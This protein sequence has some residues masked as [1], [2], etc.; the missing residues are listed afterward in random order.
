MELLSD[1]Q[2]I[3]RFNFNDHVREVVPKLCARPREAGVEV[4]AARV[5]DVD[6]GLSAALF[7]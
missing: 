1:L 6:D 4:D 7:F 3:I 5:V 2:G